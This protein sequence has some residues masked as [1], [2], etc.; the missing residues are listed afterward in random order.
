MNRESSLQP[1]GPGF[2]VKLFEVPK[3]PF[4]LRRRDLRL[5]KAGLRLPTPP[6]RIFPDPSSGAFP[7]WEQEGTGV[8]RAE[9]PTQDPFPPK[10][11]L[12]L[13]SLTLSKAYL[14]SCCR[15]PWALPSAAITQMLTRK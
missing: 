6:Q 3:S 5:V 7:A 13:A 9:E 4:L 2:V 8:L 12:V 1:L 14:P 10:R 11:G 15:Q